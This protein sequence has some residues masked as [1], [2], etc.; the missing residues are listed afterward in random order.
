MLL[1]KG[2]HEGHARDGQFFLCAILDYTCTKNAYDFEG[3][4]ELVAR[5]YQVSFELY[6]R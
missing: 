1:V 3:T 6:R 2:T 5:K 4:H